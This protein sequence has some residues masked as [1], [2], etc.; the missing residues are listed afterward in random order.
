MRYKRA[1]GQRGG[2]H[3]IMPAKSPY[4]RVAFKGD[5]ENAGAID[6]NLSRIKAHKVKRHFPVSKRK[7]S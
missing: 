4:K 5:V 1:H 6:A 2:T 3:A 7:R